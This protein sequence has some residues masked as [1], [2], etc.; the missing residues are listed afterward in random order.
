VRYKSHNIAYHNCPVE[1]LE[2]ESE[3]AG[4]EG[5]VHRRERLGGLLNYYYRKAA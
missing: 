2:S 3:H 5:E 4:H 1:E